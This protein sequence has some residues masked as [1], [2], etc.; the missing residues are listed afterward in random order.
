MLKESAV[1]SS[2]PKAIAACF[3]DCISRKKYAGPLPD[4]AVIASRSFSSFTQKHSPTEDSKTSTEF[5][6]SG[7]TKSFA[8]RPVTPDWKSAGVLGIVLISEKFPPS[9]RLIS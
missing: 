5:F 4:I 2:R 8:Y 6:C 3:I 9:Q 7:V 1:F